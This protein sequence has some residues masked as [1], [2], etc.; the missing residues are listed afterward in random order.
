LISLGADKSI[1]VIDLPHGEFVAILLGHQRPVD[2]L[3]FSGNG[4]FLA[5]GAG[6]KT[7]RVW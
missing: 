3:A 1:R 5:S 4:T 6:D 7:V 2:C